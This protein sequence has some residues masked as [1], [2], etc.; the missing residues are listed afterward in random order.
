MVKG[1]KG[2][3]NYRS[4]PLGRECEREEAEKWLEIG[5]KHFGI[6]RPLKEATHQ[7]RIALAWALHRKSNQSQAWTAEA[8]ALC[9]AANVSQQVRRFQRRIVDS[10]K[11]LGP[12]TL[13]R[14]WA[15][16]VKNYGNIRVLRQLCTFVRKVS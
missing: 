2:N 4:S 11:A 6:T 15:S 13:L 8:L 12:V 14:R 3:R 5:R 1:P 10:S 16:L 7:E 9:S